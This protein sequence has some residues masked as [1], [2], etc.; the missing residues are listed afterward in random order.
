MNEEEVLLNVLNRKGLEYKKYRLEELVKKT[1]IPYKNLANLLHKLELEG[2]VYIDNNN[3]I[4]SFP[5]HL[6]FGKLKVNKNHSGTLTYNGKKYRLT[7]ANKQGILNQDTIIAHPTGKTEYDMELITLE[8]IVKRNTGIIIGEVQETNGQKYIIDI[9]ND[10]SSNIIISAK[11]LPKYVHGDRLQIKIDLEKEDNCY[12]GEVLQV[13]GHKDDPDLKVKSHLAKFN[14][15]IGFSE[16]AIKEAEIA[17]LRGITPKHLKGRTDLRK[18][19]NISIDPATCK[20]R[21]D[22]FFLERLENGHKK[23]CINIIDITPWVYPG[24]AMWK[25]AEKK[26]S[27]SYIYDTSEPML[28]RPISNGIGS[29]KENE[30]RL[31]ETLSIEFDENNNIV[32]YYL[33]P[34]V[35]NTK[36]NCSYEDVN[37]LLE[38][39]IVVKG[40]ENIKD[41][42]LELNTIAEKL[43][44]DLINN[45]FLDFVSED[46][47]YKRD[48]NGNVIEI[49]NKR[50]GKAE[51]M[52]EVYM[53][54]ADS[55]IPHFVYLPAP[56]RNHAEP[57]ATFIREVKEELN[58]YGIK[59]R[60]NPQLETHIQIQIILNKI[61]GHPLE[62]T[63]SDIIIRKMKRAYYSP[64]N[65]GHFGLSLPEYLQ[66]TSPDRRFNDL[67]LHHIIKLQRE[68]DNKNISANSYNKLYLK[69]Y[70][71]LVIICKRISEKE[72]QIELA[73]R[74][75]FENAIGEVK[76]ESKN[77]YN[78]QITY[79]NS[80]F[81]LL[82]TDDGR[83]GHLDIGNY[84]RFNKKTHSYIHKKYKYHLYTGNLVNVRIKGTKDNDIIYYIPNNESKRL[85]LILK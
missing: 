24:T 27:S 56:Y 61:K 19:N 83:E 59:I 5:P 46:Q 12:R 69:I 73:E 50:R 3:L 52:V 13:V 64:D 36:K 29:I 81:I 10:I 42:L 45:G 18:Y 28:P 38:E 14:L 34:S 41:D 48:E 2:K 39:D 40:Y 47:E 23:V 78:A 63:I 58:K 79:L 7:K 71:Y 26:D 57:S 70:E 74:K 22:S 55:L 44:D 77:L 75:S 68:I 6:V 49:I 33:M 37:K 4:G 16:E 80:K 9:H 51:K 43:Y 65:I 62:K 35:V 32:D 60:I 11:D 1:N 30:D 53:V 15:F 17:N 85:S 21:D 67:I 82:K 84:F 76:N 8:K 25:D 72:K 20:D 54:L 31:T 66:W